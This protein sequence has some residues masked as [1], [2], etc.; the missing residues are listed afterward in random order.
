MVGDVSHLLRMASLCLFSQCLMRSV[1]IWTSVRSYP[2]CCRALRARLGMRFLVARSCLRTCAAANFGVGSSEK[3]RSGCHLD[4][5]CGSILVPWYCSTI[6]TTNSTSATTSTAAITTT[7]AKTT[8]SSTSTTT[9]TTTT[10]STTTISTVTI[11]TVVTRDSS[12]ELRY[13]YL[14]VE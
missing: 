14:A 13:L 11:V 5:M 6:A 1:L 4:Q 9:I 2:A 7:T 10:S 3:G 12:Q 8:N